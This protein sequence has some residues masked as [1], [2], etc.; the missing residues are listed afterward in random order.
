MFSASFICFILFRF[1]SHRDVLQNLTQ[2][3][4]WLGAYVQKGSSNIVSSNLKKIHDIRDIHPKLAQYDFSPE[5][6]E[7]ATF[8]VCNASA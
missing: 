5:V 1:L 2:S 4:F 3:Y 6:V 8:L 7:M